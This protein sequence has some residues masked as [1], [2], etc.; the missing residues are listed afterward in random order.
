M[1]KIFDIIPP[2]QK[3][4][5]VTEIKKEKI[6][7]PRTR[8]TRKVSDSKSRNR[9]YR[10]KLPKK[11]I[12]P[13]IAALLV[14]TAIVSSMFS[15]V[16]VV[17]KPEIETLSLYTR[18][19]VST[20]DS[21]GSIK[22]IILNEEG[23]VDKEFE[24]TGI[25]EKKAGGTIRVYNTY[26]SDSITFREGTRFMSDS[27]KIFTIADRTVIPGSPDYIDVKVT[28]AEAGSDYNI[29][30]SIFSI[31]GLS[32]TEMYDKFYGRSFDSMTGG[33]EVAV[34]SEEDLIS[35]ED[36]IIEEFISVI[37]NNLIEDNSFG[38]E[39]LLL[40]DAFEVNILESSTL[41]EVG[42]ESESF[43][44]DVVGTGQVIAFKKSDAED[45]IIKYILSE[46]ITKSI[47]P[48]SLEIEYVLNEKN[49]EEGTISFDL[50]I[51]VNVYSDMNIDHLK[52]ELI[53]KSAKEA[54][55]ILNSLEEVVSSDISFWPFW[56][57][58]IPKNPKKIN[59]S[60]NLE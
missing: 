55:L 53:G 59:I 51:K 35:A 42:D 18:L 48:D 13:L 40:D 4:D 47:Q 26:S 23:E 8:R 36:L 3:E 15:R 38:D 27:G 50:E 33:G 54:G 44:Y 37:R 5:Y 32:G 16:D 6:N 7:T 52:E 43:K 30:P 39:Y 20:S 12:L 46:L 9:I 60:F 25:V 11:N 10:I 41:A 24:T 45:F 29:E 34:V 49:L 2:S 58:K 1:K 14:I 17:I 57:N 19:N 22:G 28:A 31:P 21:E 56:I